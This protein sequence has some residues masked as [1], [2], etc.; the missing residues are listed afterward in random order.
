MTYIVLTLDNALLCTVEAHGN[1]LI[2]ALQETSS[3][4]ESAAEVVKLTDGRRLV[5][6][7]AGAP[8]CYLI[9]ARES[10]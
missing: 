3:A 7:V 10:H 2:K 4:F 8:L 5:R 1:A 6:D 9:V